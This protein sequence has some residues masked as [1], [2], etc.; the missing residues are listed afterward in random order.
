MR[1]YILT[2]AFAGCML[3]PAARAVAFTYTFIPNPQDLYDLDH[4]KAYKWGINWTVPTGQT[5]T[6]ARLS[7]LGIYD[8]IKEDGDMLYTTL[9]DNPSLGVHVYTD[10]QGG[11]DY[12]GSYG[13]H[14]GTWSDPN[15]GYAHRI[16]LVYDFGSLGILD[17]FQT[18]A[19]NGR[20]GFGIDP[21]CHYFNRRVKFQVWTSS[22]AVPEP[23][24]LSLF[25]VGI[26]GMGYLRR[27]NNKTI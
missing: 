19:A 10:N 17:E 22:T 5:I 6:G 16:N 12:F 25:G 7:F 9:L 20:F 13:T 21:D 26:A 18:Y 2:A 15:G 11:G 24:T 27:R 4:Y 8:W 23:A 14:V 1:K 3:L